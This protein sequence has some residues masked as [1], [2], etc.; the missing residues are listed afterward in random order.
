MGDEYVYDSRHELDANIAHVLHNTAATVLALRKTIPNI[1]VI[2]RAKASGLARK[3]FDLLG[4][5]IICTDADV[6]GKIV[7]LKGPKLDGAA[8]PFIFEDVSFK[9]YKPATPERIFISRRGTRNLLNELEVEKILGERGYQKVYFE[10][11][12]LS[13]QWSMTR[14]AKAVV[15]M[16]GAAVSGLVLNRHSVKLV[17]LFHPGYFVHG[18]RLMAQAIGGRWCGVTGELPPD[19]I[20]YLDYKKEWRHFALHPTRIGKVSLEMALTTL[21]MI[22]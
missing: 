2:L 4:I 3:A 9:D 7:V 8:Y 17:E 22:P 14:N 19:I 1:T 5:P 18:Y 16:H 10:D 13:E 11:I 6:L 15:A 21:E 20:K 12:P